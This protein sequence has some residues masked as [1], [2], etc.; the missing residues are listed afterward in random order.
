MC[1]FFA[2]LL[3]SAHFAASASFFLFSPLWYKSKDTSTRSAPLHIR[4]SAPARVYTA[5]ERSDE[6]WTISSTFL[7]FRVVKDFE[8]DV[9]VTSAPPLGIRTHTAIV[10][11]PLFLV[12][13]ERGTR[14]SNEPCCD[15][16]NYTGMI[17]MQ[18]RNRCK[19]LFVQT[20]VGGQEDV[21]FIPTSLGEAEEL[22]VKDG[23]LR[24]SHSLLYIYL[25]HHPLLSACVQTFLYL[26]SEKVCLRARQQETVERVGC[27]CRL[28]SFKSVIPISSIWGVCVCSMQ[29]VHSPC[30]LLQV[31]WLLFLLRCCVQG[32][33]LSPPWGLKVHSSQIIT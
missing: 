1:V 16:A 9:S 33:Q 27:M 14:K 23:A 12:T 4:A 30:A 3:S 17:N 11:S 22:G 18:S 29:L 5:P 21:W 15:W 32:G 19:L 10:S 2:E 20:F 25:Q 26:N 31:T 6:I 28:C 13:A 24:W 7:L 8:P